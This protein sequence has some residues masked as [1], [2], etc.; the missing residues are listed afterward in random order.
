MFGFS[1]SG[2]EETENNNGKEEKQD[3]IWERWGREKLLDSP[4]LLIHS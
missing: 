1:W 3:S 4:L 2:R